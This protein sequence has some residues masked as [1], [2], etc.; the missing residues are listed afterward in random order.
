M[1]WLNLLVRIMYDGHL[2]LQ[3]INKCMCSK[4]IILLTYTHI[5]SDAQFVQT[6]YVLGDWDSTISQSECFWAIFFP[7]QYCTEHNILM[8]W[9]KNV[10]IY[11]ECVSGSLEKL[12]P[13]VHTS[14]S[15]W[16][17]GWQNRIYKTLVEL[18]GGRQVTLIP[19]KRSV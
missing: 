15:S 5:A 8:D 14:H 12:A 16:I 9:S 7:L 11:P 2:M 13:G 17:C 6:V 18:A 19:W 1:L 10:R 3:F 4:P